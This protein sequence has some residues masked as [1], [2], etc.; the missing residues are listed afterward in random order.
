[1]DGETPSPTFRTT[2]LLV[3]RTGN[4]HGR[5]YGSNEKLLLRVEPQGDGVGGVAVEG[6]ASS[7]VAAGGA[8]V[9]VVSCSEKPTAFT[10]TG[11]DDQRDHLDTPRGAQGERFH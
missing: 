5:W 7:V 2:K 3:T 6:V 8:G 9:G 10:I 11:S 4:G 1:M